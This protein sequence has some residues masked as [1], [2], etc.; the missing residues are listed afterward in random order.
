MWTTRYLYICVIAQKYYKQDR[1]NQSHSISRDLC[2]FM[3]T[4]VSW[5]AWIIVCCNQCCFLCAGFCLCCGTENVEIFHPLFKGSLCLK[6]K[7]RDNQQ[8][9]F[10]SAHWE[11]VN[12][13]V[14][15]LFCRV[16]LQKLCFV[17]MKTDISRTA[18]SAAMDW[19][20]YCVGTTAA[21]GP[22]LRFSVCH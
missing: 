12:W 19:R 11:H 4:V 21:A 5:K 17:M 7:V 14:P 6:C 1:E 22:A 20:S 18:P 16:T 9:G 13:I 8:Q 10:F 15:F 2:I 3:C